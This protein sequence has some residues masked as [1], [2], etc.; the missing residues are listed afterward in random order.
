MEDKNEINVTES[1]TEIP[2]P[3][4]IEEP[5]SDNDVFDNFEV[6][7]KAKSFQ[8]QAKEKDYGDYFEEN[9]SAQPK[10][11][12]PEKTEYDVDNDKEYNVFEEELDN[13]PAESTGNRKKNAVIIAI[14]VIVILSV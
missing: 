13:E 6:Q 10:T 11:E 2:V 4:I 8:Q 7:K 5:V 12:T 1:A 14:S 3:E 9:V